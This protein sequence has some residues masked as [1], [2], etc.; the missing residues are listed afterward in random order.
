M[1]MPSPWVGCTGFAPYH[2]AEQYF[3]ELSGVELQQTFV[4]LPTQK[5]LRRLR[6]RAPAGFTFVI[7]AWQLVTHEPTSPSYRQLPRGMKVAPGEAGHFRQT[8]TV[9]E[10]AEKTLEAADLLAAAA[11]LFETPPSFT[12]TLAHRRDIAGFFESLDRRHRMIWNPQGLWSPAEVLSICRDLDLVPCW[13]PFA[14]P[15]SAGDL[16]PDAGPVYLRL[17]GLGGASYSDAQ[18]DWLAAQL[19]G[20]EPAC[21]VFGAVSLFSEAVRLQRLL[22]DRADGETP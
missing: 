21:C 20:L 12:P 10:A 19:P 7:R 5:A 9:R 18:L 4:N 13:D 14:D 8:P 6:D 17:P 16:P 1:S 15:S 3:S 2:P 22:E 11:V